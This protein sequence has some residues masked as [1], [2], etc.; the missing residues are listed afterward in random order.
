MAPPSNPSTEGSIAKRLHI[1]G[2]TNP[3]ITHSDLEKR[4]SSF[5]KVEGVEGVGIDANG[6]PRTYAYLSLTT[7]PAQLSRCLSLLSGSTWKGS[8]LKIGEARQHYAVRLEA[9][10]EALKRPLDEEDLTAAGKKK[11]KA[12]L[13]RG[14]KGIEAKN[15]DLVE[16]DNVEGRKNWHLTPL[17]HL[18]R[19]LILRPSHPVPAPTLA[20]QTPPPPPPP[21]P[22]SSK[23]SKAKAAKPAKA[24]PAPKKKKTGKGGLKSSAPP[25]RSRLIV[26]DPRRYERS[27]LGA[28]ML[29]SGDVKEE[30]G[31]ICVDAEGGEEGVVKWVRE[32][33]NGEELGVEEVL[34][35]K[36]RVDEVLRVLSRLREG[37]AGSSSSSSKKVT[38]EKS[39]VEG[40]DED[41]D[42]EFEPLNFDNDDASNGDEEEDDW[43]PLNP[44]GETSASAASLFSNDDD[45]L[46]TVE[47]S[48]TI[49][50]LF[51]SKKLPPTTTT[52]TKPT[53]APAPAP[54]LS[55]TKTKTAPPPPAAPTPAPTK[56]L[57][58]K[59]SPHHPVAAVAEPTV[60][61]LEREF[62]EEKARGL[63]VLKNLFG[64]GWSPEP[65][66][67]PPRVEALPGGIVY[68]SDGEEDTIP[69]TAQAPAVFEEVEE[70]ATVVAVKEQVEK[71]KPV[72]VVAEATTKKSVSF[73][74]VPEVEEVEEMVVEEEGG[75]E[76]D[77]EEEDEAELDPIE[78]AMRELR[79]WGGS[80]SEEEEEAA[81]VEKETPAVMRLRGGAG[82]SDVSDESDQDLDSASSESESES[83]NEDSSS[84]SDDD[85]EEA[86]V[87]PEV[88]KVVEVVAAPEPPPAKKAKKNNPLKDMFAPQSDEGASFSLLSSLPLDLD[89]DPSSDPT[90]SSTLPL[91]SNLPSTSFSSYPTT[92]TQDLASSAT[93]SLT[94]T[95]K[96]DASIPYF[97]PFLHLSEAER[98]KGP[99]L[100]A[101]SVLELEREKEGEGVGGFWRKDTEEE[102]Q[103]RWE[104][105]HLELTREYKKRHREAVKRRR[106]RGAVDGEEDGEGNAVGDM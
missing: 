101:K 75:E 13:G 14:V 78:L 81:V 49:S 4:F 98:A 40:Q 74:G 46:P 85:E 50:P 54:A 64:G 1:G 26:I 68:N 11:K 69:T 105:D 33:A 22:A 92:S 91:P 90:L 103:A 100:Q 56:P 73:A 44:A 2:L 15:M 47:S 61:P 58:S 20:L 30:R 23:S 25:V 5:G 87:V 77:E 59:P 37:E 57:K 35:G 95:F 93:T 38:E 32:G 72:A 29:D 27:H 60:D 21:P 17:S 19:P 12:K 62:L 55:S 66:S 6:D 8:L 106:R 34:I 104:Q 80:D 89:L 31:W 45:P 94:A 88:K 7:T 65:T 76:E 86:V 48:T 9:E 63:D 70:V 52:N 3:K 43:I 10:R 67:P 79:G 18:I 41:E 24:P 96:P 51:T 71:Q 28:H 53:P 84:S 102:M 39:S 42:M 83:E 97:F 36:K 16:I 99:K 82:R